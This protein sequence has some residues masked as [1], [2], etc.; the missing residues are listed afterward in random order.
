MKRSC[1]ALLMMIFI[2]Q[3]SFGIAGED[4]ESMKFKLFFQKPGETDFH[5]T[6]KGTTTMIEDEAFDSYLGGS[7]Q[8]VSASFGFDW[9]LY[10]EGNVTMTLVFASNLVN[11]DKSYDDPGFKDF[12][13]WA[14]DDVTYYQGLNY[15]ATVTNGTGDGADLIDSSTGSSSH[16]QLT[17]ADRSLVLL[18]NRTLSDISGSRGHIDLDLTLTIPKQ[19]GEMALMRTQYEGV[20]KLYIESN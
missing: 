17:I 16:E 12:M 14:T 6:K 11:A 9:A 5:F 18:D 1:F 13:L 7:V 15:K 2:V 8:S 4:L 19:Q 20:V 3:A 10:Y